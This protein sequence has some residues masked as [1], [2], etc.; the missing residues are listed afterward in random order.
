MI[1]R[2]R[3]V[4][5]RYVSYKRRPGTYNTTYRMRKLSM[6]AYKKHGS[7]MGYPKSKKRKKFVSIWD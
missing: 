6:N 1:V 7:S 3:K 4:K 5:R 2:R